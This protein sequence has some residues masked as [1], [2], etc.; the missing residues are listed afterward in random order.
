MAELF[1]EAQRLA[2]LRHAENLERALRLLPGSTPATCWDLVALEAM[3]GIELLRNPAGAP[4]DH[5]CRQRV[6]ADST[7][8]LA[9]LASLL[10]AHDE[11]VDHFF[12][13][14]HAGGDDP[15]R[16]IQ[17][18][19]PVPAETMER[20]RAAIE[21]LR[22][23]ELRPA[24][25]EPQTPIESRNEFC[26]REWNAGQSYGEINAMLRKRPGWES[27]TD[28]RAVRKAIA[29]WAE[30]RGLYVRAGQPGRR[31]RSK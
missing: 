24:P 16:V 30:P 10:V 22:A 13:A 26:W 2:W 6:A 3:Q 25:A 19:E 20:L 31:P 29:A 12:P 4:L 14:G 8:A 28:D 15:C 9:A 1:N 5:D 27:F 21:A 18:A 7:P 17:A 23:V 11:A